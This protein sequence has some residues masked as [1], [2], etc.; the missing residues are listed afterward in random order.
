MGKVDLR[1]DLIALNT[2][3][4]V[5]LVRDWG[6]CLEMGAHLSRLVF[7]ERTRMGFLLCDS[8]L[9]K[10]VEY[11]FALNFQL[12]GQIVDSNLTHPPSISSELS[13]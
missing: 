2:A 9:W 5:W 7:F 8:D 4:T 13:R 10:H 6:L 12:P 11:G 3:G 1:L